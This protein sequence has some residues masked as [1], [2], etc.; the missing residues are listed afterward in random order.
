M[1]FKLLIYC[2]FV[3]IA[4]KGVAEWGYSFYLRNHLF[5]LTVYEVRC[6]AG[7]IQPYLVAKCFEKEQYSNLSKWS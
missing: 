6:L 2:T 7:F 1:H 5:T 4:T 3:V